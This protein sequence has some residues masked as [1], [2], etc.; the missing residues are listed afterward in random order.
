MS[1][2]NGDSP[3]PQEGDLCLIRNG[4]RQGR[5]CLI[6]QTF[7]RENEELA[8]VCMVVDFDFPNHWDYQLPESSS[9]VRCWPVE[10][11]E[12]GRLIKSVRV[13]D[14]VLAG[15]TSRAVFARAQELRLLHLASGES[16]DTDE[17]PKRIC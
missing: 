7:T 13:P 17:V 10:S 5:S 6:L 4:D 3:S 12:T 2:T 16:C 1:Q 14:D 15:A 8:T 11:I 9:R